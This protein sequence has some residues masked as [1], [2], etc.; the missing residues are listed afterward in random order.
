M[1]SIELVEG[2]DRPPEINMQH[3]DSEYG[4]TTGCDNGKQ[5]NV[6]YFIWGMKEPDY[7]MRM[8]ATG[9][10]LGLTDECRET[11]RRCTEED[12]DVERKFR[13]T[14]PYDWHFRY[15]HAVDDHNNLRHATPAVEDSWLTQRWECRVFSF[16]LALSEINT[17]L[18]LRYFVFGNN[19]IEG[20]PLLIVFRHRLAWQLINNPWLHQEE[21]EAAAR[22]PPAPIHQLITAPAHA[23]NR[24]GG[25]WICDAKFQYQQYFCSMKCKKKFRTYC[26]CDP[27]SWLCKDCLVPHVQQLEQHAYE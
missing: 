22:A 25:A 3:S 21:Q 2:K 7:V 20:C 5:D 17:F 23:R 26:A 18:A 9:G 1:F 24:S 12:R 15:R 4:K 6:P 10:P 11:K 14:C 16:L 19:T 27:G 13:Y 8:M